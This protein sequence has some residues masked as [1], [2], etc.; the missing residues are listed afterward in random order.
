VSE[1]Y[2]RLMFVM[3]NMVKWWWSTKR[4][5]SLHLRK[6]WKSSMCAR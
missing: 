4:N 6:N 3:A 2:D 5:H 1:K